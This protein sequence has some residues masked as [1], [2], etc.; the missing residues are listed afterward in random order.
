MAAGRVDDDNGDESLELGPTEYQ[1]KHI[2]CLDQG[3][4]LPPFGTTT[5]GLIYVNPEGPKGNAS[6]VALLAQQIRDTFARMGMNDAET[7]ALIGGG[8]AVGKA[9]GACATGPGSCPA[10]VRVRVCMCMC[11]RASRDWDLGTAFPLRACCDHLFQ[12]LHSLLLP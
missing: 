9:H 3:N 7:V 2:P 6:Q 12:T 5:I 1:E 10:R 11:M 8:H 4:C